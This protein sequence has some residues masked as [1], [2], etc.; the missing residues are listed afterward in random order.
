M[1]W[2][3]NLPAHLCGIEI[4]TRL[5]RAGPGTGFLLANLFL[6]NIGLTQRRAFMESKTIVVHCS[7]SE[8]KKDISQIIHDSFEAFLQKELRIFANITCDGVS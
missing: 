4:A 8:E 5:S 2:R 7:S 3:R 6:P 1:R